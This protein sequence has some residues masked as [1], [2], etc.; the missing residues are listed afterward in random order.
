MY[1]SLDAIHK[2]MREVLEMIR[3]EKFSLSDLHTKHNGIDI[4]EAVMACIEEGLIEGIKAGRSAET[5]NALFYPTSN[6]IITYK[7]LKFLEET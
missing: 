7:G 2:D 4:D 1:K 3:D 5:N 6:I